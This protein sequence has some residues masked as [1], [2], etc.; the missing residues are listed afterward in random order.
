[1]SRRILTILAA[2][3]PTVRRSLED[4][5]SRIF[6]IAWATAVGSTAFGGNVGAF[7][8]SYEALHAG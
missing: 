7:K 3:L 5:L 4:L 2:S 1:M 8:G 6:R